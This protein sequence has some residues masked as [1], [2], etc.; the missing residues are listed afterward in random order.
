MKMAL[1]FFSRMG[2]S[3]DWAFFAMCY[4]SVP[5]VSLFHWS[6]SA[7]AAPI[8]LRF[9]AEIT[10]LAQGIP[11]D[12]GIVLDVGEE[13]EGVF[14]FTPSAG[15]GGSSFHAIQ[16]HSFA[17]SV[18]GLTI[19]ASS[20][21]IQ[22]FD[23]SPVTDFPGASIVDLLELGGAFSTVSGAVPLNINASESSFRIELWA[24]KSFLPDSS[25]VLETAH[26]PGDVAV[27]NSLNLLRQMHLSLRDGQGGAI[28]FSAAVGEFAQVPEP[29]RM[30]FIGL[31]FSAIVFGTR[32]SII[33]RRL[34]CFAGL[35]KR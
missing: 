1:W 23:D 26:I 25:D 34:S 35:Q 4:A 5:L 16:P 29:N 32:R 18:N 3:C 24:G 7:Y 33:S 30:L 13:I 11:F 19:A 2:L 8:T 22:S 14:T 31:A 27:W 17:L 6:D 10:T 15:S 20:F 9:K 28:G 12:P 21:E